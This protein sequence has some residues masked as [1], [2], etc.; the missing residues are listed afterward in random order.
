[1]EMIQTKHNWKL[2]LAALQLF[3]WVGIALAQEPETPEPPKPAGRGIP[4]MVDPSVV[5][6]EN[7]AQDFS[8]PWHAD[9]MPLTGLQAP[10]LGS[11]ESRHSYFTPG[12]QYGSMFQNQ[13]SGTGNS[14][15][16]S[17]TNYFGGNLSLLAEGSHS[18]LSVNFSG[19][20]FTTTQSGQNN[21]WYQQ[22]ALGQTFTWHRWQAQILDQFSYLPESQFGFAGGTPLSTP[23][24]GGSLGSTVPG[25]GGSV[26]PNQSIYSATGPRYSN[27][28]V[29]QISY[30]TSARG[31]ITMGGSYGL[32][33]F[34][35][36]GNVDSDNYI[37]NIGYNYMLTKEDSIGLV[38]RFSS[39]H[40]HG[41]PQAIGD[42]IINV[43][44]GKKITKRLAL[45]IS[46]G[47]DITN[48]RIPVGNATQ[49]ISGSGSVNLR[50]AFPGG[51][52]ISAMY[53]HTLTGGSGV[54]LGANTDQITFSASTRLGRMW[55]VHGNLGFSSDRPLANQ[56]GI[57]GNGYNSLFL[58]GGVDR[59]IGR[60]LS[61]SLAYTAQ[62][63]LVN[64]TVCVGTGCNTSSTQN[65]VTI[66]IQWHTRPFVLW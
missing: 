41:D 15:G 59:P 1:M 36:A 27:A 62:I 13:P 57:Q 5:Q 39:Y 30:A 19:G 14:G 54:L 9:T 2:L 63:Q 24:I 3:T 11:P 34:T 46:A 58:G 48:Y 23:G 25:I 65:V 43:A 31:S 21:S 53:F 20:G 28:F 16:W 51:T 61:V 35:Q 64:P 26:I 12:L 8:T 7:G 38:Y 56:T 55:N 50:Y 4:A 44:Y 42:Q 60:N 37:G 40:F 22:L 6:D 52:E 33:R 47:P 10:A 18:Q 49:T 32:L 66:S 45:Q 17:S 29:G